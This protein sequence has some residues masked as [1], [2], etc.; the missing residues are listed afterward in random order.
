MEREELERI[1]SV[2]E[3]ERKGTATFNWK[4]SI[5]SF[6]IGADKESKTPSIPEGEKKSTEQKNDELKEGKSN[7]ERGGERMGL[8]KR[9][10]SMVMGENEEKVSLIA[11]EEKKTKEMEGEEIGKAQNENKEKGSDSKKISG[12]YSVNGDDYGTF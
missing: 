7:E 1:E 8:L 5:T 10:G 3:K 6:V 2:R 4:R 9:F 11:K 12:D